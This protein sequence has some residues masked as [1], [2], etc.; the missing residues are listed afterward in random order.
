MTSQVLGLGFGL[1]G[2]GLDSITGAWCRSPYRS[3]PPSLCDSE[4]HGTEL[5]GIDVDQSPIT[6]ADVGADR[7]QTFHLL[8]DG[9]KYC[10]LVSSVARSSRLTVLSV[11]YNLGFA[12]VQVNTAIFAVT[13]ELGLQ[14][15]CV[16]KSTPTFPTFSSLL[17]SKYHY[18][19]V[20]F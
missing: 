18:T 13:S 15:E 6:A 1:V 11:A 5:D 10:L 14:L 9:T 2:H 4:L 3:P 17:V 19:D 8:L 16:C 7:A 12:N 20:Q